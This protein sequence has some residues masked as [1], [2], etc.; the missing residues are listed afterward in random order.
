MEDKVK[1]DILSLLKE[2]L[3]TLNKPE[4]DTAYIKELSDH[5]IH[6][7][8]IYQDEDSISIA[9][10][11]YSL[12][13]VLERGKG[14]VDFIKIKNM[15]ELAISNLEKGNIDSYRKFISDIFSVISKTD[16]RF[17]IYIKEVINQASI[18]KGSIIYAHGV[19]ATKTAQILGVSLWDFYKY[20]G[21]KNIQDINE[22]ISNVKAR[23]EFTRRLLS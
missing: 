16:I 15:I 13:K 8:S 21:E 22:D 19:S 4:L 6:N 17:K 3:V 2:T 9:V 20:L 1:A 12:S 10:L 5:T 14:T 23:L 11:I 18:K 7:A